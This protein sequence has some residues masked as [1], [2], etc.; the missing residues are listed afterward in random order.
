MGPNWHA[1]HLLWI[2]FL[3]LFYGKIKFPGRRPSPPKERSIYIIVLYIQDVRRKE[4]SLLEQGVI[5]VFIDDSPLQKSI[6]KHI[7]S[8]QRIRFTGALYT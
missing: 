5:K 8:F 4:E 1:T 6:V 3:S 2:L 7:S